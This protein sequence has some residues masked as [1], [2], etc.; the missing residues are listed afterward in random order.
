MIKVI[1]K[2]NII[3]PYR[4]SFATLLDFCSLWSCNIIQGGSRNKTA[5][6]TIPAIKFKK[7]FGTNPVVRE[8]TVPLGAEH[9]IASVKVIKII[10]D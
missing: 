9:F 4:D 2:L 10:T 8:Y 6:I 5:K 1:L 3:Y 7:I